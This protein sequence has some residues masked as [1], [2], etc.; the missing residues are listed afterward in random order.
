MIAR[1]FG[2]PGCGKTTTL[3]ML[4]LDAVRSGKYKNVYANV[5]L[6]IEG[7]TYVPFDCFGKYEL[8]EG[9]YFV[10]EATINAGDRDW[11]GFGKDKIKYLMEHRHHFLDVVFFSQEADGMDKKIRAITDRVYYVYKTFWT[12]H[13]VSKAV[14]VP[15]KVCW[16]NGNNDGGENA[17]RILMGYVK[18]PFLNRLFA[19]IIWRSKYYEF[20]DSWECERLPDLPDTYKPYSVT[21]CETESASGSQSANS[22]QV[23]AVGGEE[24][25]VHHPKGAA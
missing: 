18:P 6:K 8:R 1:Y 7:V 19:N 10:D 15:Y 3:T 25:F 16:P 21:A 22:C 23:S 5:H 9:I 24:D 11:K 17:G 13:W 2:L 20:F 14:R 4:A 12:G